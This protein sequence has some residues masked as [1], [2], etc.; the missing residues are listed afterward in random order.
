[1][2]TET[3]QAP[4]Q[5]SSKAPVRRR[6]NPTWL[7]SAERLALPVLFV[8]VIIFFTFLPSTRGS[9]PTFLNFQ[10][11]TADQSILG[12][13]ALA[14]V[15]PL[16]TGKFDLSVGSNVGLCSMLAAGFAST[17]NVSTPIVIVFAVLVGAGVGVINGFLV[18]TL[19]VNAL[20]ATLGTATVLDG[21]VHLYSDGQPIISGIPEGVTALG[22]GKLLGIPVTLIVLILV[23][24]V[25]EYMLGFTPYGR[26]VRAVGVNASASRLVGIRVQR[27]VFSTFV[28]TGALC[29]LAAVL[30]V[31]RGGGASPQVGPGFLLPALAA[32]FLGATTFRVGRYNVP[33]T[34]IAIFFLATS[35]SGLNLA[36]VQTWVQSVFNGGALIVAV[37]SARLVSRRSAAG[38]G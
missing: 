20:I 19:S 25:L 5:T 27:V 7:A 2:T 35:V 8:A 32:A 17:S 24:L 11:I 18:S 9:F 30:L 22:N 6:D 14:A 36:G 34:L 3:D 13:V 12:V 33:G 38:T 31:G 28:I 37:V 10:T 21:L 26:Y 4:A 15:L 23:A 16:I 29:G 1:M